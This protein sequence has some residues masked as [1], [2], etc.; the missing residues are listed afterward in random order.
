MIRNTLFFYPALIC[1]ALGV[2]ERH[3]VKI[4][5]LLLYQGAVEGVLPDSSYMLV[6]AAILI[7]LSIVPIPN[8]FDPT[9]RSLAP[10]PSFVKDNFAKLERHVAEM[11]ASP[12][13]NIPQLVDYVVFQAIE[14]G[15]SDIHLDPSRDGMVVR[16]RINGLMS[17][18]ALIPQKVTHS[19]SNRLKVLSNLVI[20]QG[21][22]PQDGR[23]GT[24]EG[25]EEQ[26]K[27]EREKAGVDFRIAFMPTLHGERIVIR[28]LGRAG[29]RYDVA[30]LGMTTDQQI[31]LERY[32]AAPQGMV[33]LTGPTGSGKTTTIYAALDIIQDRAESVRSIATLED[34]I[35]FDL[36]GV[37]QSQVNEAKEFTFDKG[38][39][40]LLRQDPDVIMVGEIRDVETARIA[41]QAGMT[42][43][44]I[45]TTVHA[46]S[47]STT[48]SRMIEMGVAPFS[49]NSA[50]TAVIAQRLVRR[51][52]PSC[53]TARPIT[54]IEA[55]KLARPE[56]VDDIVVYE[57]R[58]CTGCKGSGFDGRL[59]LFE[60]L[61]ITESVRKIVTEGASPDKIHKQAVEEGMVSLFESGVKAVLKGHTTAEEI[62][63]VVV[64]ERT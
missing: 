33:I 35:E 57:G 32:V 2:V 54:E 15:A 12:K 14:A 11:A 38:L 49:L 28:I 44:L 13:P 18:V 34:P 10:A 5:N 26:Q 24:E 30:E 16:Y 25:R 8:L 47:T 39:R 56:S 58:G 21:Y 43:H 6:G 45:I 42:G 4:E 40:A 27:E 62:I 1:A 7:V 22:L 55:E 50:V 53:R 37:N 52:C 51:V 64:D 29:G 17:N 9:R 46:N 19:V 31:M 60:I 23:L 61:E 63:R 36:P 3:A 20:Y 59:A 41:I 48:F